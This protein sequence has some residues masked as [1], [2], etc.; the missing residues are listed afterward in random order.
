MIGFIFWAVVALVMQQWLGLWEGV[1]VT[2]FLMWFIAPVLVA[3]IN[4]YT[5]NTVEA[6]AEKLREDNLLIEIEAVLDRG[7]QI[8]LAH[9]AY[10]KKFVAQGL[11]FEEL[12]ENVK[13]RYN[14]RNVWVRK[15]DN[16]IEQVIAVKE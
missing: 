8:L 1:F 16:D 11:T 14:D 6:R 2:I 7:T 15:E 9:N 4:G 10:D 3:F 12:I 13:A 5:G